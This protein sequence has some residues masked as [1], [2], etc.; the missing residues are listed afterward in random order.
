MLKSLGVGGWVGG[1]GQFSVSPRPLGFG[2]WGLGVW[3][4][5]LTIFT[6]LRWCILSP[7][8]RSFALNL[9]ES[10]HITQ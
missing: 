5:G 10:Q 1:L 4:L 7:T 6:E 9:R 8:I 2:F 3:C